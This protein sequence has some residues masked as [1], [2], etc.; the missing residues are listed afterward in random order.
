MDPQH[1]ASTS[2]IGTGEC[3]ILLVVGVDYRLFHLSYHLLPGRVDSHIQET[4]V[5]E[6]SLEHLRGICHSEFRQPGIASIC[7]ANYEYGSAPGK[8]YE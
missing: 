3:E 2:S 4:T 5:C 6:S 1:L 7:G 8:H